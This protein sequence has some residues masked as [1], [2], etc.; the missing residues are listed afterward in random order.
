MVDGIL[1]VNKLMD[2]AK[3]F[4]NDCLLV[5]VDF[6]KDYDNVSWDY[7]RYFMRR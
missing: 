3:R 5:K 4:K 6:S 7:L 1:V 2:Y